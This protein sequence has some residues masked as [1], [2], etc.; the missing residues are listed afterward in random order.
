MPS[1][2]ARSDVAIP[3]GWFGN[4]HPALRRCWHPV[5]AADDVGA[6]PMAVEL[7]GEH[8]VLA[9]IDGCVVAFLDEC[10]HRFS[11]LSSG[12]VVDGTLQ[13]PY[14]GWRFGPDGHCVEIPALSPGVPIPPK[15]ACRPAAAVTERHGLV[16]LAPEPPVNELPEV[17]ELDDPA[18]TAVPIPPWDWEAGAAQMTDNF[19]DVAHFPYLHAS[20][21][22][23]PE[24]RF[25]HPYEVVRD[26]LSFTAVTNHMARPAY[27]RPD[28][29]ER[30]EREQHFVCTGP[31]CLYLRITYPL[32]QVVLVIT[33]FHQPLDARRTRLWSMNI[34]NDIA[35]GRC[36]PEETVERQ[37][38]VGTEDKLLL[39]QL[40][41][42]AIPLDATVE[43]HTRADRITLEYRR[44]LADLVAAAAGA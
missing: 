13:C 36:A 5:A 2:V 22:G 28:L 38:V 25:V 42:K 12:A 39:E 40:R 23:D 44:L 33:F 20:S 6:Q 8:W 18:F 32:E 9:R 41:R 15:A 17:P 19:L 11:P 31:H 16:W 1:D 35:D 24:D 27:A 14:H 43:V 34:R 21:F 10:P 30:V 7:L 3:P 4:D 29:P 37:R 26:G